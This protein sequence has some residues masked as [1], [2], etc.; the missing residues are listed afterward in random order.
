MHGLADMVPARVHALLADL[1]VGPLTLSALVCC[2]AL[3][4]ALLKWMGKQRILKKME[5]ARQRRDEALRKMEK[6]VQRFKQQ[7]PGQKP[8]D[9]LSLSLKELS[10]R[11]KEGSLL[12]ENVLYTY[13][14]KALEVNK[15]TNSLTDFLPDCVA[16]LQ[17]IKKQKVKGLLYGVPVSIKDHYGYKGHASTC[18]MVHFLDIP[19][20]KDC[21]LVQVLKKQGA[22]PFVKT[23]V[24]QSMMNYD[25][26][27]LI[28]G[29]TLHPL[30]HQKTPGGSSGGEGALVAGGGSILG[31]GSDIA[32][33][34]RVPSS[35]CGI[36]GIKPTGF[37]LSIGGTSAPFS[38]ITSVVPMLGPMA[39]DVDSLALCMKALLCEE[40]FYLDPKVPPIPFNDEVYKCSKP[41]RIGF[42]DT[43]GYCMPPP[44]MQ[45]AVN[46]TK[47]L[48]EKAG[49][50]LIPFTPPRMDYV[51][52]ELF[53]KGLFADGASMILDKFDED[54]VDPNLKPQI[55]TYRL[56]NWLKWTLATI[57]KPVCPRISRDLKALRGR[58]SARDL[59]EQNAET[60][61]YC[62][63]FTSE[64]RNLKLDV[65]LCPVMG[66]AYNLGYVGKLFA[67]GTYTYLYNILNF[68]AGVVPVSTVTEKDEEKLTHYEGHY[69]DHWDNLIKKAV[70]GAVGLPVAVQCVALPWQEELCL[71]FMKEVETLVQEEK[72]R[73]GTVS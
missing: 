69:N 47:R 59:W 6:E 58:R 72:R 12:P 35:F 67:T 27:N 19:V 5:R 1:R 49:H 39:R 33:S 21:V 36:C 11:L 40:L 7:N 18:G 55:S 60:Q 8:E 16:Q 71:R 31:F 42:Y 68:P 65:V 57:L 56:P 52:N 70:T 20:E 2:S 64:W 28:F 26:S 23:N 15:G 9:I 46:E 29:Q 34:I 14:E 44:C 61:A 22:I 51:A 17:E 62:Q 66:P 30:N 41:L 13:M 63:E 48:L 3:S 43:D 38:G 53:T 24:P 25:C 10:D 37:R 50:T 54:I 32:G 45:R 4:L 73:H